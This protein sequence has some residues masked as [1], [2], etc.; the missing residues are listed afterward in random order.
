MDALLTTLAE[1]SPVAVVAIFSIWRISLVM[2]VLAEA[3]VTVATSSTETVTDLVEQHS[4]A[5]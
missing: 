3:L 2:I 5:S 4:H 1:S